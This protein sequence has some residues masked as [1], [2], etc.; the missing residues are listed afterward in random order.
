MLEQLASYC[1]FIQL[2]GRDE[3]WLRFF[4][5]NEGAPGKHAKTIRA[6]PVTEIPEQENNQVFFFFLKVAFDTRALVFRQ[7]PRKLDGCGDLFARCRG[8]RGDEE[9]KA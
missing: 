3:I 7:L 9:E 4:S 2:D 6:Q 8:C 5:G 1:F